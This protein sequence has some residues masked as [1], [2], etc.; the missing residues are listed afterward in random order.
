MKP[1][2]RV[3]IHSLPGCVTSMTR[4]LRIIG[5]LPS[6]ENLGPGRQCAGPAAKSE[7]VSSVD[8]V[9]RRHESIYSLWMQTFSPEACSG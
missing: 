4:K 2:A 1:D 7:E 6:T 5:D 3:T 9:V 8:A